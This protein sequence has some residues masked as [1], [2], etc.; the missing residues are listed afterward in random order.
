MKPRAKQLE[1]GI[2]EDVRGETLWLAMAMVP[3]MQCAC[4]GGGGL[5][6]RGQDHEEL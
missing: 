5:W 2:L 4:V 1:R 6:N 3:V